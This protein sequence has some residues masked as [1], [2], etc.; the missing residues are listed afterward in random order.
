MSSEREKMGIAK[1]L[2]LRQSVAI[3]KR[4]RLVKLTKGW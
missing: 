2:K 3:M 1:T 4:M